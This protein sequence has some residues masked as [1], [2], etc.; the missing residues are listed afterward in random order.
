ML[1]MRLYVYRLKKRMRAHG[2]IYYRPAKVLMLE[3]EPMPELLECRQMRH[4]QVPDNTAPR[5][6]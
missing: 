4:A 1:T 5:A 2:A 3:Q 6:S